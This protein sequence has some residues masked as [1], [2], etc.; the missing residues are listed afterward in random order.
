MPFPA[1]R[2]SQRNISLPVFRCVR[3]GFNMACALRFVYEDCSIQC[4]FLICKSKAMPVRPISIPR[5]ELQAAT[6]SARL[7][8]VCQQELTYKIGRVV[9]WTA[10][11]RGR[12]SAKRWGD[13]FACLTTRAVCLEL[14]LSLETDNFIMALRQFVSRGDQIGQRD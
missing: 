3:L 1:T 14:V 5:L 8:Q 11:P 2:R 13:L 9:F 12:G 10:G 7:Y 6:L 4:S